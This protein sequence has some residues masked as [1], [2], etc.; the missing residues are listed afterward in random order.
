MLEVIAIVLLVVWGLGILAQAAGTIY[1]F[2]S[3]E[4]VAHAGLQNM[5]D[6]VGPA[7]VVSLLTLLIVFWP[8]AVLYRLLSASK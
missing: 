4:H 3:P 7:V 5:L 2:K 8:A 1:V 6:R